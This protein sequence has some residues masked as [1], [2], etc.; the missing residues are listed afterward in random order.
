MSAAIKLSSKLI[1]DAKRY[2]KFY[3]RS[4]PRQIEYWSQIG[5]IAEENPDITYNFIK[6][7]LMSMNEIE[8]GK[9]EEYTFD[10]E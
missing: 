3:N 6:D 2:A 5:K 7:I 4:L 8:A 9:V 1:D 10:E